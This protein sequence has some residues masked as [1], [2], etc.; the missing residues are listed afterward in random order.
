MGSSSRQK[1]YRDTLEGRNTGRNKEENKMRTKI[2]Q[3]HKKMEKFHD[4]KWAED[5][6]KHF[7]KE[8]IQM[9]NRHMQRCSTSLIIREV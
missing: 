3:R 1:I 7:S 5:L 4:K 9:A 8:D 2:N 6:N